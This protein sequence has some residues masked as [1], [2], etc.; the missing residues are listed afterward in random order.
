[1]LSSLRHCD[2]P[3]ETSTT[4]WTE[5]APHTSSAPVA[6]TTAD[7]HDHDH[8]DDHTDEPGTAS[9]AP[10]P[11]ESVGCEPHGDHWH[12]DGPASASSTPAA[13]T[14]T[15]TT[16][17]AVGTITAASSSSSVFTAAAAGITRG[18]EAYG[19]AGLVAIAAV[20]I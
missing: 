11:T 17:S 20:A 10:S 14:L 12:C 15:S 16:A 7:D 5:T 1:M 8:D 4:L 19:L 6:V 13:A 18:V 3:R 2:G 9:L